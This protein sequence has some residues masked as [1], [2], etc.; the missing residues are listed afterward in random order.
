MK[1]EKKGDNKRGEEKA[2][3]KGM[4]KKEKGDLKL[5]KKGRHDK[6]EV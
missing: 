5:R 6:G 3:K 2:W 4:D 1:G